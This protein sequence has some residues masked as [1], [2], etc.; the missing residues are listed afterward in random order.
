M[1]ALEKFVNLP[2]KFTSKE[3]IISAGYMTAEEFDAVRDAPRSTEM[4]SGTRWAK[5]SFE[6]KERTLYPFFTLLREPERA[7]YREYKKGLKNGSGEARQPK[8]NEHDTKLDEL[9][10][11]LRELGVPKEVLAKAESLRIRK[12][13][14]KN[15]FV[16]NLFGVDSVEQLE[17]PVNLAYV[18]FRGP[19]G[20][21]ADS[22]QPNPAELF[23]KGFTPALN[24]KQVLE[25]IDKLEQNA[26][27]RV[28]DK[29]VDLK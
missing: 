28:R 2:K 23:E 17:G 18:M 25:L 19:D 1:T 20:E 11:E 9:L 7:I 4:Q 26:G 6:G 24:M 21:R 29:I 22:L 15:R 13:A 10:N 12:S 16:Q 8:Q 27:I 5:V 3:Q 14:Y